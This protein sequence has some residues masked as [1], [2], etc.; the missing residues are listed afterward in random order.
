M[1]EKMD[2]DNTMGKHMSPSMA[3]F[4]KIHHL[5]KLLNIRTKAKE[6]NSWDSKYPL[7]KIFSFNIHEW[8]YK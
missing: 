5:R 3:K 6:N 2:W 4:L 8:V 1:K 7:T